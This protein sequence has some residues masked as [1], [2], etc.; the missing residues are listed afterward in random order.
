VTAARIALAFAAALAAIA[1]AQGATVPEPA[2]YRLDDYRAPVPATIKGGVV[3]DTKQLI[4]LISAE[5]TVLIDVL[6]APTRPASLAPGAVW[7]PK[8]RYNIH[9]S[10][11]LP[12]VGYGKLSTAL[13]D[14]FAERLE[15]LSGG[16]QT[17]ALVFYCL[18]DCWM[19]WNAAKRAIA[20]GYRRVYWYPQGTDGWEEAGNPLTASAPPNRPE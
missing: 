3:L 8:T 11:W 16:E 12:D 2:D 9:G 15:R 1:P 20:L 6:P 4:G 13:E 19:S 10:V 18:A 7:L 5:R 14:F 17:R